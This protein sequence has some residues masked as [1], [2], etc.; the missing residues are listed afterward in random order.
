MI[1]A[2]SSR[3]VVSVLMAVVI[4]ALSLLWARSAA[5][6]SSAAAAAA[7]AAC[8][9]ASGGGERARRR[10]HCRACRGREAS[11]QVRVEQLVEAVR[12]G[13]GLARD[14][15]VLGDLLDQGLD[16][17]PR[18][19]ERLPPRLELLLARRSLIAGRDGIGEELGAGRPGSPRSAGSVAGPVRQRARA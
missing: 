7:A 8:S 17:G 5:T 6:V 1:A 3:A 10:A 13:R 19:L 15:G 12:F 16:G 14:P 4:E 11:E 9:A 18:L 2:R